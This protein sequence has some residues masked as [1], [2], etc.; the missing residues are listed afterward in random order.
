MLQVVLIVSTVLKL[1][2]VGLKLCFNCVL[3]VFSFLVVFRCLLD[4][5]RCFICA[6]FAF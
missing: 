2:Q 3:V 1:F 4:A 5:F 6:Y